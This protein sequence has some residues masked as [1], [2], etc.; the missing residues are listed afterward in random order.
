MDVSI[1]KATEQRL[2]EY[3]RGIGTLLDNKNQRASF[4]TYAL[5][6]LGDG[7]RKSIEPIAARACADP[8]H[9]PAMEARLGHFL[10]N[11][12][13][14]D[15]RVRLRAA[16]HALGEMTRHSPVRSWILD[17]T[18]FVKQGKHSVG[19]QRQYSG[20]LGKTGNCQVAV[21]LTVATD[22]AHV[23]VDFELYLPEAWTEDPK[24]R[25]EARVPDDVQ[26]R[27]KLEL[28]LAMVRRAKEDGIP[29]GIV[30]VDC[31]Y[32]NSSD[33]REGLRALGLDY[34]VAI[35]GPTLVQR[36][37]RL[38]RSRGA[39]VSARDIATQLVEK[40]KFRRCTWRDGTRGRLSA[41][42]A[43]VRVVSA[44]K[45]TS[46]DI[47]DR[48]ALWLL[49]EWIDGESG[50]DAFKFYLSNLPDGMSR[51]RLVHRI[52]ERYR[53]ERSYEDLKGELGLDHYEGRRWP[54]WNHH[55]SVVICCYAFIV[56]E[57]ARRFPPSARRTQR[58][59]PLSVAA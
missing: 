19:V 46:S 25:A 58:D 1:D 49:I 59:R 56:A 15:R 55:V 44:H 48:E 17:D 27:T 24:R 30:L 43:A 40:N 33:F 2:N 5:G 18:G 9:V 28:G 26:F 41:R 50:A 13:W 37:D 4:A 57:L 47:R 29:P 12:T 54:G 38:Q 21:S 7:E 22:F 14:S 39:L 45:D 42:F 11:A 51:R 20:T 10:T 32:G 6:L 34:A 31:A 23:P 8:A 52:K 36:L 35:Q 53:I 16:E 3:V